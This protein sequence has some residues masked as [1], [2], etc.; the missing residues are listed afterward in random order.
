MR[1]KFVGSLVA[2]IDGVV[3]KALLPTGICWLVYTRKHDPYQ[4]KI[5]LHMR[6]PVVVLRTG[7]H[8]TAVNVMEETRIR[9][10]RS[11]AAESFWA[12]SV[13]DLAAIALPEVERIKSSGL[14]LSALIRTEGAQVQASKPRT[15]M[16]S[17]TE[18]KA[19]EEMAF[20]L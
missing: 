9:S 20:I 13:S 19:K 17:E 5:A 16:E 1:E 12:L 11:R 18:T 10:L 3:L 7:G 8:I 2:T 4:C 14:F 6:R 15:R